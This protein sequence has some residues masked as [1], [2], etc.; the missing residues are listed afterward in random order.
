MSGAAQWQP[1]PRK[2]DSYRLRK[3]KPALR[4]ASRS[5]NLPEYRFPESLP[6]HDPQVSCCVTTPELQ[7]LANYRKK[8][9][10]AAASA[11]GQPLAPR[12]CRAP[13]G[14][15]RPAVRHAAQL[16]VFRPG[17]PGTLGQPHLKGSHQGGDTLTAPG[18]ADP[19]QPMNRPLKPENAHLHESHRAR[20][21]GCSRRTER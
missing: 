14:P 3:L 6:G 16:A 15:P 7:Q 18:E 20:F 11:A 2:S 10:T 13:R 4:A 17:Y 21:P 9:R 1:R 12:R 5:R 19:N 8:L